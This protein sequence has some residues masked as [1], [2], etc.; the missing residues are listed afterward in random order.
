VP[1]YREL[2]GF[3]VPKDIVWWTPEEISEWQNVNAHFISD[4]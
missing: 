3:G 2:A 4:R 1:V